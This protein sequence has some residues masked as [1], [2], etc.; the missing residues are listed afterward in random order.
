MKV[1]LRSNFI[2]SL[3]YFLEIAHRH[4]PVTPEL[5]MPGGRPGKR[6]VFG[7]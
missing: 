6:S 2:Y 3:N 4:L 5:W 7:S 1:F